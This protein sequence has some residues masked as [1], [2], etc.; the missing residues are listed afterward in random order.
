MQRMPNTQEGC[1]N[2]DPTTSGGLPDAITAGGKT[3]RV[4]RY[5]RDDASRRPGRQMVTARRIEQVL[6]NWLFRGVTTSRDEHGNT[7]WGEVSY[8]G[9][10]RLMKI[11]ISMDDT[12]IVN[13]YL[14]RKA[15][16][17]WQ[18]NNRGYFQRRC[19][20]GTLEERR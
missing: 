18:N 8:R 20:H 1:P 19:E 14:D 9:K 10:S 16:K 15:T 5:L 4:S 7:H 12:T 3:R 11:V 6:D 13:A 2:G 17:A